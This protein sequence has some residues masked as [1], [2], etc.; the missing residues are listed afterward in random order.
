MALNQGRYSGDTHSTHCIQIFSHDF[1]LTFVSHLVTLCMRLHQGVGVAVAGEEL[2][3]EHLPGSSARSLWLTALDETD[4]DLPGRY[5]HR[6]H[7]GLTRD[8]GPPGDNL[9]HCKSCKLQVQ[10]AD[11]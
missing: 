8:R 2:A 1:T 9:G 7:L 3:L 10:Q 6:R 4:G 5:D 11:W